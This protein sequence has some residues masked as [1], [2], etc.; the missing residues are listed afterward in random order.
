MPTKRQILNELVECMGIYDRLAINSRDRHVVKRKCRRLARQLGYRLLP[1][2][3]R[4]VKINNQP[5]QCEHET[6]RGFLDGD[7]FCNKCAGTGNPDRST[8]KK[9]NPDNTELKRHIDALYS[10]QGKKKQIG[11]GSMMDAIIYERF[12]GKPTGKKGEFHSDKGRKSIK[13]FENLV[14]KKRLSSKDKKIIRDTTAAIKYA[15]NTP[16]RK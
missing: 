13:F 10:G 4:L 6:C 11:D 12:T 15:L 8:S 3:M 7:G 16:R 14:N 1:I 2:S 5:K 9:P